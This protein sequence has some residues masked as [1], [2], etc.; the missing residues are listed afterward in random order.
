MA[1]QAKLHQGFLVLQWFHKASVPLMGCLL[2]EPVL[3]SAEGTVSLNGIRLY[4]SH[5]LPLTLCHSLE[6]KKSPSLIPVPL[7]PCSHDRTCCTP[8]VKK[9]CFL[10]A[11]NY[12]PWWTNNEESTM[13]SYGGVVVPPHE[14]DGHPWVCKELAS[15]LV[16]RPPIALTVATQTDPLGDKDKRCHWRSQC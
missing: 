13:S 14:H 5:P 6:H 3:I 10:I 16:P 11:Q 7:F 9:N 8:D 12:L 15:Y 1:S 4:H 2:G